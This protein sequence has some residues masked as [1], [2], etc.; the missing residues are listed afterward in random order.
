MNSLRD[1]RRRPTHPGALLRE[2]VL[3]ALD[4]T[5]ADFAKHLGL[6]EVE[7]SDLLLEKHAIS[8]E[9]AHSLA[10]FLKTTADSWLRMQ[11]AVDAWDEQQ[12]VA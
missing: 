9:T 8:A 11:Q 4:I 3:P 12:S 5:Q 6:S 7:L 1:P 2:D 10:V